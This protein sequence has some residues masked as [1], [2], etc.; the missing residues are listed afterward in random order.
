MFGAEAVT[1]NE[2]IHFAP[3]AYAPHTTLGCAILGHELTHVLQQRQFSVKDRNASVAF[4]VDFELEREAFKAGRQAA[5]QGAID[6]EIT[7]ATSVSSIPFRILQPV[8]LN[9]GRESFSTEFRK[10]NGWIVAK[11]VYLGYLDSGKTDSK[12][13]EFDTSAAASITLDVNENIYL[14]GHGRPGSIGVRS[15]KDIGDLIANFTFPAKYAGQIRAFCC[16]AGIGP[17]TAP[18]DSGVGELAASLSGKGSIPN[19]NGVR[20]TGA[21]GIA[22]N[23]SSYANQSRVIMPGTS[24][25][26][27]FAEIDRTRGPVDQAW[28][29]WIKKNLP[30]FIKMN[31]TDPGGAVAP[32]PNKLMEA[33]EHAN[34]ISAT[35]YSDLESTCK[36]DLI[37]SGKDLTTK[38]IVM[39]KSSD[40]C[41]LF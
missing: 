4:L 22:L 11:D 32:S 29:T 25:D 7:S 8:I 5:T 37:D 6:F 27:V 10:Y 16:S 9:V 12:F 31:G 40:T 35:F 38:R 30:P 41:V 33:A 20:V 19:L 24:K 23:C 3:G 1:L 36:N 28:E 14:Q 26:R 18:N 2:Q 17:I 39:P 21:A 34:Q 15:A 13:L